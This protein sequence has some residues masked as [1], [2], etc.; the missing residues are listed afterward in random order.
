MKNYNN[1]NSIIESISV[2]KLDENITSYTK[3]HFKITSVDMDQKVN[4][5]QSLNNL[6]KED[7]SLI[8]NAIDNEISI[9]TKVIK[10][11]PDMNIHRKATEA[12]NNFI[13]P[14]NNSINL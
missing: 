1:I 11:T 5:I 13:L 14:I 2:I 4:I 8:K 10:L 6:N 3:E 9:L 12:L 7:I